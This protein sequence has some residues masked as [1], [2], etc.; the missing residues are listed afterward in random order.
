VV[1]L[2]ALAIRRKRYNSPHEFL[3]ESL[4]L[5]EKGEMAGV[6][7]PDDFFAGVVDL[8]TKVVSPTGTVASQRLPMAG[9]YD[10]LAA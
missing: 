2:I 6:V 1:V 8:P 3:R 5:F 4:L 9:F 7:K 10:R